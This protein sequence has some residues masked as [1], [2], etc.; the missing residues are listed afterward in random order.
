MWAIK[1]L[2]APSSSPEIYFPPGT[3]FVFRLANPLDLSDIPRDR[4][5]LERFSADGVAGVR[6]LLRETSVFRAQAR[7]HPS[8]SVNLLLM[9]TRRQI[10][11]AFQAAG[12]S[13]P[14]R[15]GPLSLY[16]MYNAL[17]RRIGY[18]EAPMNR[19]NLQGKH[20]D[21]VFEKSLDTITE[22]HHVRFW[23]QSP[24][25]NVWLGTATEDD[26]ALQFQQMHWTHRIDP[27]I[28]KERAKIVNE[29]AFTGC[30]ESASLLPHEYSPK[31]KANRSIITDGDIA[32]VRFNRCE[33][34]TIMPG[35]N[36]QGASHSAPFFP[37]VT[38]SLR[39]DLLRANPVFTTFNLVRSLAVKRSVRTGSPILTTGETRPGLDWLRWQQRP[40]L[41]GRET[42]GRLAKTGFLPSKSV[43]FPLV[44]SAEPPRLLAATF[45]Q[46]SYLTRI[47]GRSK[48]SS[49]LI[50]CKGDR[51]IQTVVTANGQSDLCAAPFFPS[52]P[53]FL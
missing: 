25:A 2:I 45:P 40:P 50:A 42:A 32:V 39:D 17:T 14:E 44:S 11:L 53:Y 29:L 34:P 30:L 16:R 7:T 15:R 1:T 33:H 18:R 3:E 48:K 19:L 10:A 46:K 12:W 21:F 28:D 38:T 13:T 35:V 41:P 4:F 52:K 36:T 47:P 27:A 9:G 37:R 51:K 8:D 20:S 26:I 6:E 24:A 23:K 43:L 22:R 49:H 31:M 5:P